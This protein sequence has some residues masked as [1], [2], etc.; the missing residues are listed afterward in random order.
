M[1]IHLSSGEHARPRTR[2]RFRSGTWRAGRG[3]SL[4]LRARVP[5]FRY[6]QTH[7]AKTWSRRWRRDATEFGSRARSCTLHSR[8]TYA[9]EGVVDASPVDLHSVAIVP[10]PINRLP[11]LKRIINFYVRRVLV[12]FSPFSSFFLFS[13]FPLP[14]ARPLTR[15]ARVSN[16]LDHVVY[17]FNVHVH[18]VSLRGDVCTCTAQLLLYCN[19]SRAGT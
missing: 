7:T 16:V 3:N 4:I 1:R 5:Y 15:T 14:V 11:A 19:K 13:F 2:W 9:R 10:T 8:K 12:L 18:I 17:A 6:H